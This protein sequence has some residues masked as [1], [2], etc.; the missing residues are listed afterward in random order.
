MSWEVKIII[1]F[2]E[3]LNKILDKKSTDKL[4]WNK[5]KKNNNGLTFWYVLHF[6]L[7]FVL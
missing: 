4:Q 7:R 3:G 2:G 6:S 5:K 1:L